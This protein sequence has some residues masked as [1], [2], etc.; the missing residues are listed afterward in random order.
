MTK[1]FPDHVVAEARALQREGRSWHEIALRL[2][3][4]VP[5]IRRR[6]DPQ[7]RAVRN[8]A[9]RKTM[10][11][12]RPWSSTEPSTARREAGI[13]SYGNVHIPPDVLAERDIALSQQT[14]LTAQ[15]FGDPPP[16]RSALGKR[17]SR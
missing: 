4:T 5:G 2:K 11:E 3:V 13:T 15:A 17:L 7:Y 6:L 8:E 12:R 14:D 16:S 10:R 9:A 1:P